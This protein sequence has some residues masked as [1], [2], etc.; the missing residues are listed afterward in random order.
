MLSKVSIII[1]CYNT[2]LFIKETLES[3]FT[4]TYKNIEV[5]IIDDGSTDGSGVTLLP[6][7]TIGK[8][9][10]IAAGSVVTKSV[11]AESIYGG[12]PAKFIKRI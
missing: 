8:R 12:V 2:L 1:P 11:E 6:G 10:V 9:A 7:V 3:V 5:I 4:Q